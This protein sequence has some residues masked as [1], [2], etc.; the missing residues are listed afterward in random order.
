MSPPRPKLLDR[1]VADEV[2]TA[3]EEALAKARRGEIVAVGI[4][5][6][7]VERCA[8]TVYAL[9]DGEVSGLVSG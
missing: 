6:E 7:D 8:S 9:G 2:V 3:L 1:V 5:T 4:V